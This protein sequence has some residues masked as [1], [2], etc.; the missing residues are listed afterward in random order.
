MFTS[1]C[2]TK[3]LLF[4]PPYGC[5]MKHIRMGSKTQSRNSFRGDIKLMCIGGIGKE[6]NASHEER[7]IS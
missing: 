3:N 5:D 4:S 7:F 2:R 1:V 6:K